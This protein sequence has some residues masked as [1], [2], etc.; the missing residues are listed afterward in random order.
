M[1]TQLLGSRSQ[2]SISLLLV[3]DDS[4]CDV[5]VDSFLFDVFVFDVVV[6]VAA[7]LLA[8]GHFDLV[9]VVA[10][11]RDVIRRVLD[12]LVDDLRLV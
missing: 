4:L 3:T 11:A 9:A 8:I 6:V 2:E 1:L 7:V 5:D 12:A 10:L